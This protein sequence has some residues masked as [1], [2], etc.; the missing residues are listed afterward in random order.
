M[1]RDRTLEL[2][3]GIFVLLGL[4][5][6]ATFVLKFGR[7]NESFKHYYLLTV[8]FKDASGLL[9]GSDVLFSGA[10]IGRVAEG[11]RLM[12]EGGGVAVPL[13]IFDYVQIPVGSKFS[14]GSSGLL[15]DRFVNVAMPTGE[16]KEFIAKESW[17]DG[18]RE[19]GMDDLTR[20]GNLLIADLRGTVQNIN[21]TFTRLNTEAL[22]PETLV[23][24]RMSIEHL[25]ETTKSLAQTS[26]KLDEVVQKADATMAS[27]KK[28]ADE[29][30]GTIGEARKTFSNATTLVRDA[31]TGRGA[32]PALIND[33]SLAQ[34]LRALIS[35]LRS[36]G[37]LFYKNSAA[38]TAPTPPPKK[39]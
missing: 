18:T 2:K 9:K 10:K 35:N 16:A 32:L 19:T 30:G 36:H 17:L 28:D 14:V 8:R 4:I 31:T 22:S 38:P 21:G 23:N 33:P 5:A 29:L 27:A 26:A 34:D 6:I 20:E 25:N 24:L 37:I 13:R 15:G 12:R 1:N 39:R 11:P 7:L 3:V